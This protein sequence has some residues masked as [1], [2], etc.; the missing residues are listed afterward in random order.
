[1]LCANE[2]IDGNIYASGIFRC[3]EHILFHIIKLVRTQVLTT[4][5]VFTTSFFIEIFCK[6]KDM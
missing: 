6:M 4:Y 5:K 1:M 2:V 3:F